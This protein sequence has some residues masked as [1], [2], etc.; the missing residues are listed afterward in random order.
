[1]DALTNRWRPNNPY[2]IVLMDTQPWKLDDMKAIRTTWHLLDFRFIN[3]EKVWNSVPTISESEFEDAV[4]PIGPLNYKRM[5]HF[6]FKGFTDVPV[7]MEY[8]YLM[9]LDDDTC[10]QDNINFDVFQYLARRDAAYAY[11]H[12]V[13]D[14]PGVIKGLYSY[15]QGYAT[16]NNIAFA[17]E[18]LYNATIHSKRGPSYPPVYNTNFEVINTV[19]YREEPVMKFLTAV[20][21]SNMIFHRRW[22]DAPLRFALGLLFW[23]ESDV[24]RLDRF[25]LRHSTWPAFNMSESTGSSLP[26]NMPPYKL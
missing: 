6:F 18:E 3:I 23:S 20:S 12:T 25:G 19:R 4:K 11:A 9:R 16:T 24:V 7:L 15:V 13:F 1:M 5:C 10:F 17:N 21:E 22:G 26:D 2:T 14:Y 8:K